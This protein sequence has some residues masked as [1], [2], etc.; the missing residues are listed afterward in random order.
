MVVV[1]VSTVESPKWLHILP[2]HLHRDFRYFAISEI[3]I[4]EIPLWLF[5]N[6]FLLFTLS[7][8]GLGRFE[9]MRGLAFAVDLACSRAVLPMDRRRL[10]S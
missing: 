10:V 8:I 2:R 9:L 5:L 7:I 1:S 6:C 4:F 3:A